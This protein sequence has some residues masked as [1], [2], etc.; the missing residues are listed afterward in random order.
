M[1]F[2]DPYMDIQ[3]TPLVTAVA[4]VLLS[5]IYYWIK[6]RGVLPERLAI[7]GI[8]SFANGRKCPRKIGRI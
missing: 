1:T 8:I 6:N 2:Y 5:I 4:L 3:V 7:S